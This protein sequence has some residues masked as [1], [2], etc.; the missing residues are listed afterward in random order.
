MGARWGEYPPR[1]G[2]LAAMHAWRGA[3]LGT[4]SGMSGRLL[5]LVAIGAVVVIAAASAAG[6]S[7]SG[8]WVASVS[9]GK[10]V[11]TLH[12]AGA[13]YKGT[14]VQKGKTY[15]VVAHGGSADGASQVMLT[16]TPGKLTTMCGLQGAKLYCETSAGTATFKRA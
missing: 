14:Y 2:P 4:V 11:L 6:T 10:I 3:R 15:K 12:K 7:L 1:P 16:L 8:K 9:S 13:V 5:P